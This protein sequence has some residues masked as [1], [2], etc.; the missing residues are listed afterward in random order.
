MQHKK[1]F[2]AVLALVLCIGIVSAG[3]FAISNTISKK[4]TV[5]RTELIRITEDWSGDVEFG[6]NYV[7]HTRTENLADQEL[8]GLITHI[9]IEYDVGGIPQWLNPAWFYIYYSDTGSGS[10]PPWQGE[11]QSTFGWDGT[12]L[13]STAMGGGTWNAP[14]GYDNLAT[15]TFRIDAE[16]P[17]AAGAVIF[18]TWVEA[19]TL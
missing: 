10:I 5:T 8:K 4:V 18:E 12:K 2:L 19:P 6:K 3:Y 1:R 9:T 11:I 15:I 14:V 13:V 7:F 16:V 17:L